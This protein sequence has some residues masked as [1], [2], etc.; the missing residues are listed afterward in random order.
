MKIKFMSY[1]VLHFKNMNTGEID[2]D[3]YADYIK[4][5]GADIVG[6]NEIYTGQEK[7]LAK[8]L[9]FYSCF[10]FGY[11][12]EGRPFGNGIVSRFPLTDCE[13]VK[14]PDPE[15]KKY[16][17]YYEPRCV[18]ACKAQTGKGTL[19]INITH[20]GLNPDEQENAAETIAPLINQKNYILA[21]DFN[22]KP[23]DPI[24]KIF[25]ENL[26]DSER[27][28]DKEKF[29]FPSD[30]P[31]R[32]IDYIFTGAGVK[33]ISSDIPAVVISDHRPI[34]AQIEIEED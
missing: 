11:V 26:C 10:A 30:E 25:K 15:V 31:N 7:E 13:T 14:I 28:F 1:N 2:Y 17:G 5:S 23:N 8:R 9:N 22:V 32:K 33:I 20:F 29:S 34:T 18:L 24:L 19:N 27:F 16:D 6:L 21:G 3:A 12:E 4:E